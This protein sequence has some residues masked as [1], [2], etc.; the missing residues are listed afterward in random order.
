MVLNYQAKGARRKTE[1]R[2][3]RTHKRQRQRV[4]GESMQFWYN[5]N[6]DSP[7]M[8]RC[9]L[10]SGK[11]S[12]VTAQNQTLIFF[13]FKNQGV[14]QRNE[15][16]TGAELEVFPGQAI[17]KKK[18][19]PPHPQ[20]R[21]ATPVTHRQ[22]CSSAS[23]LAFWPF[24]FCGSSRLQEQSSSARSWAQTARAPLPPSACLHRLIIIDIHDY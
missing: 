17:K 5:V 23:C 1:T 24:F 18:K 14:Q 4:R 7:W 6:P 11:K 9:G 15:L 21:L 20:T 2:E 12:L 13:F 3:R 22:S 8:N 10:T 16:D 19:I